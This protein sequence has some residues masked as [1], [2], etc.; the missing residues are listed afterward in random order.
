MAEDDPE[1]WTKDEIAE[2]AGSTGGWA[3]DSQR[4]WRK[5]EKYEAEGFTT[6]MSKFGAD[7]FGLHHR[8]FFHLDSQDNFWLSAED[9]CEGKLARPRPKSRVPF[10]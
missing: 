7:A 5:G 6:Y 8:F 10:F 9:G 3:H 2:Y 4:T 1:G